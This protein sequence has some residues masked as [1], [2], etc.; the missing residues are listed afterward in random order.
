MQINY[1]YQHTYI[2]QYHNIIPRK[3][4]EGVI[5]KTHAKH[6]TTATKKTTPEAPH[7]YNPVS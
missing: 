4:A 1:A 6:K 5:K 3:R 2:L 7:L